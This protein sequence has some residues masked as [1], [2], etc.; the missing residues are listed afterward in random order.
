MRSLV[1]IIAALAFASPASAQFDPLNPTAVPAAARPPSSG[2]A[3]PAPVPAAETDA[4]FAASHLRAQQAGGPY[5]ASSW[6]PPDKIRTSRAAPTGDDL[7]DFRAGY[8]ATGV[9]PAT[10]AGPMAEPLARRAILCSAL[11]AVAGDTIA[12]VGFRAELAAPFNAASQ[13][14]WADGRSAYAAGDPARAKAF[15][16]ERARARNWAGWVNTA[17][18]LAIGPVTVRGLGCNRLPPYQARQAEINAAYKAALP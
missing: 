11:I 12:V 18:P 5:P 9:L 4:A 7:T 17:L 6:G 15:D 16:A 1:I 14:I 3:G 8:Y 10:S 2:R 13:A